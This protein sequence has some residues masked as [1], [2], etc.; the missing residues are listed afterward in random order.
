VS[1][2]GLLPDD[3]AVSDVRVDD[4]AL[5]ESMKAIAHKRRRFGYRRMHVL[6]RQAGHVVNHKRLFRMYRE[7]K[8]HVR[9]IGAP[10][11][12]L[13]PMVPNQQW[14]L[15]YVSDQLTN[16]RRFRTLTVVDNCA[17]EY[18]ALIADT[19]L[20]SVRVA[21]E[22]ATIFEQHG[23]PMMIISDNGTEFTPN[24]NLAF[25]DKRKVDWH[26]IAPGK[27]TQNASIESFSGRL[28]DE[29]LNETLFP[30]LAHACATLAD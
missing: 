12:M 26:Y 24:A 29:L 30:A 5:R 10:A 22:L 17:R 21:W 19:S 7:E 8:L 2:A 18:L 20:S 28:R 9:R 1:G 16:G 23:K 6:L 4:V 3:N 11:L 15:D 13:V 27:P 14:S 25:A